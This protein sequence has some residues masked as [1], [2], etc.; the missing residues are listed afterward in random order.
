M[1]SPNEVRKLPLSETTPVDEKNSLD[2]FGMGGVDVP[3]NHKPTLAPLAC[4]Q[5]GA[6]AKE[7][8]L[9]KK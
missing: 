4:V 6:G 5:S 3:D 7:R 1:Q 8:R 9:S 2:Y